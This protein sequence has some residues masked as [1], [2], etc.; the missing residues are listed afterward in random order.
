M[1]TTTLVHEKLGESSDVDFSS[2][3]TPRQNSFEMIPDEEKITERE[4][5]TDE[6]EAL[7]RTRLS[8]LVMGLTLSI[9]LVALD[10]VSPDLSLTL[11]A[12]ILSQRQ[13][14]ELQMNSKISTLL[15]G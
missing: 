10:F 15:L 2:A 14:L 6:P 8:L 3:P 11:M 9:F 13:S 1:S 5:P 12:R 4:V 7:S